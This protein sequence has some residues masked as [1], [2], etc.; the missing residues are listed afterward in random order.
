MKIEALIKILKD[1][2]LSGEVMV[3]DEKGK[4]YRYVDSAEKHYYENGEPDDTCRLI[5]NWSGE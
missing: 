2:P 4:S 5:I 3:L 1:F